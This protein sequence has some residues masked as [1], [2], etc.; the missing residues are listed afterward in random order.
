VD[1]QKLQKLIKEV[2]QNF[3]ILVAEDN[4]FLR[5]MIVSI[6]KRDGLKVVEAK[7]GKEAWEQF[8]SNQ[9]SIGVV[10]LDWM[11]PEM[12]GMEVCKRI[13]SRSSERYVYIIFLSAIEDKNDIAKCLEYGADDY[14]MKPLHHKEFLARVK[15]GLRIIALER[16]LIEANEKLERLATIDELTEVLNRRG[17]F[18]ELKRLGHFVIRSKKRLYLLMIDI[19]HFKRVN[20][21]YGHRVGDEVLKELARRIK[22][23]LRP[24]DVVGRY[25]G[26][27]FLVAFVQETD[28]DARDVAERLRKKVADEPF[29]VF[30]QLSL[31]VTISVGAAAFDPVTRRLGVEVRDEELNKALV[32]SIEMADRALYQAKMQGRN[33]VVAYINDKHDFGCV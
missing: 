7:N 2:S 23:E 14:I 32:E 11:M 12:D 31:P 4:E 28:C 17:L 29:F 1:Y 19:D 25:G 27:E 22:S 15:V 16:L 13:R 26:E 24:Y 10:V 33:R 6:L 21:T 18:E 3:K 20:D 5:Q 30:N 8:E 9:D